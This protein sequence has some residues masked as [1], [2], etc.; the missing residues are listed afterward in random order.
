MSKPPRGNDNPHLKRLHALRM[1]EVLAQTQIAPPP[2]MESAGEDLVGRPRIIPIFEQCLEHQEGEIF[3]QRLSPEFEQVRRYM[4]EDRDTP[5]RLR[6]YPEKLYIIDGLGSPAYEDAMAHLEEQNMIGLSLEGQLIGRKGELSLLCVST[7]QRVIMFDAVAIGA[8]DLLYEGGAVRE[9]L[10]S[11]LTMKVMNDC[12]Q[13]SDMLANRFG[14]RLNN[15]YDTLAAHALFLTWAHYAGYLPKF[16][17]SVSYM[18]RAYLGIKGKDLFFPHYRQ[19]NLAEDTAIWLERP[20]PDNLEIGAVRCVAYLLDLQRATREAMN[21]PFIRATECLLE[22]VRDVS[23]HN[24]WKR[25][26]A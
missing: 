16:S 12:R 19:D 25:S 11:P 9:L 2:R 1:E 17:Y 14:V 26:T 13:A 15:V 6:F 10:E 3:T 5:P 24:L 21:S 4:W 8:D 20:L 23:K 22:A 18:A 7:K